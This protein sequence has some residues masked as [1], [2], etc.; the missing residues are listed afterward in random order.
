[1]AIRSHLN[2]VSDHV[3]RQD[4]ALTRAV[5]FI[6]L[7]RSASVEY[8]AET[9]ARMCAELPALRDSIA[10]TLENLSSEP[11]LADAFAKEVAT[12]A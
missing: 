6:A 2:A 4:V 1:M 5:M 10:E 3:F 12:H 7:C 11:A 9:L 8:R